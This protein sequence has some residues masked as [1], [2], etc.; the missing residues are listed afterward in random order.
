MTATGGG[1]FVTWTWRAVD[2]V[3]GYQIQY[4]ANEAF[5]STDPM[6]D[7]SAE[8]LSYTR[9]DL[10]GGTTHYLRVR[11]FI[12]V[13]DTRYES[14]WSSHVTGMTD[15]PRPAAP[16]GLAV[17]ADTTDHDSIGWKW[18]AVDGVDGY[19]AQFSASQPFV[20]TDQI[21]NTDTTSHVVHKLEA[22]T[23]GY[24]QVRSV[25]GT[26]ADARRS[27]WSATSTGRTGAAPAPDPLAAPA[28]LESTAQ[29]NDSIV[30][31]WDDVDD[32]ATYE[33]DQR[34]A[35]GTW[36]PASCGDGGD[37]EVNTNE[38]IATE[39]TA[40]TDYDFR[41]KAVPASSDTDRFTESGWSDTHQARTDG[42][43]PT[44]PVAGGMGALNVTW[45]S[46][47]ISITWIWDRVSS[48]AK[49]DVDAAVVN[50]GYNDSANPC[51]DMDYSEAPNT[52]ATSHSLT[53]V[54]AGD[55]ALLCVRDE[56]PAEPLREPLLRLGRRRPSRTQRCLPGHHRPGQRQGRDRRHHDR[57][58]LEW[59][60]R[61]G[62]IQL[63]IPGGRRSA[64]SE[65][66]SGGH[67]ICG[68]IGAGRL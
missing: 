31:T 39:L 7:V 64:R 8:T 24:L 3:D 32:A 11:S 63:R 17:D 46:T 41:V 65:Q 12:V 19:E 10:E 37:N 42:R 50:A 18:V 44:E 28:N 62:R 49:Y 56:Q 4:S 6:E 40:G 34:V 21:F 55:V 60:R 52:T 23:N 61:Q 68:R 22:E 66:D 25:I 1:D 53:N 58:P 9:E 2:G 38:C 5:T 48:D 35:G 29:T 33:V 67:L 16:T 59:V 36:G 45:E 13:M 27:D 26:G 54:S 57:A 47:A 14:R 30:L 20:D 15:L 51:R 43:A